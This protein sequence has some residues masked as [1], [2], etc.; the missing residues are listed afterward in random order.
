MEKTKICNIIC[1]NRAYVNYAYSL[2]MSDFDKKKYQE[3]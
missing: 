2:I 3:E 1:N